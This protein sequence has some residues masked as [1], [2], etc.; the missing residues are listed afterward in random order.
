ML[1]RL[2]RTSCTAVPA[3]HLS[4]CYAVPNELDCSVCLFTARP[5]LLC[6]SFMSC[7]AVLLCLSCLVPLYCSVCHVLYCCTAL[8][9]MSC[10]ARPVPHESYSYPCTAGFSPAQAAPLFKVFALCKRHVNRTASPVLLHLFRTFCTAMPVLQAF[11]RPRR[12]PSS[13]TLRSGGRQRLLVRAWW[14]VIKAAII[15]N[16][17]EYVRGVC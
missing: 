4:Y 5:V 9:V 12:R 17:Y 11:H 2:H 6:L 1:L 7:T 15:T 14:C 16:M 8:S 13:R 3:L 10:T